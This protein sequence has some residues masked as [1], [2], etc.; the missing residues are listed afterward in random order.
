MIYVGYAPQ[1]A[2]SDTFFRFILNP[3]RPEGFPVLMPSIPAEEI[4]GQ[5]AMKLYRYLIGVL[6]KSGRK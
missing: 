2:D 3:S 6:E 5:K 4:S 1:L